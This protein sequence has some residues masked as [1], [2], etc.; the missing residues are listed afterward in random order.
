VIESST[1]QNA[2]RLTTIE[3]SQIFK[4]G[5]GDN[6]GLFWRGHC[7]STREKSPIGFERRTMSDEGYEAL[8][9][10]EGPECYV[11]SA[12]ELSISVKIFVEV[13]GA[14]PR[15]SVHAQQVSKLVDI[16]IRRG[17]QTSR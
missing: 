14:I 5:V 6:E 4:K 2:A 8:L 17:N 1:P 10:F 13:V 12:P 15:N 11:E 3:S 16:N 9:F 7:P